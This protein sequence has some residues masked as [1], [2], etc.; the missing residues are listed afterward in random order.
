MRRNRLKAKSRRSPRRKKPS[1]KVMAA[2]DEGQPQAPPAVAAGSVAAVASND[3]VEVAVG[4]AGGRGTAA[5]G[6]V[7]ED[8]TEIG[9]RC[10]WKRVR[11]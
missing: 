3:A 5:G 4:M 8:S 6:D 7:I 11:S 1:G 9:D 10:Q 2:A